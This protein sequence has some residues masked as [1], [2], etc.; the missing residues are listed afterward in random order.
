MK[1]LKNGFSHHSTWEDKYFDG[2]LSI[3][4]GFDEYTQETV[5]LVDD[6]IESGSKGYIEE[7]DDYLLGLMS[8]SIIRIT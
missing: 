3:G 6:W 5:D 7:N 2:E 4:Q 8:G 1:E